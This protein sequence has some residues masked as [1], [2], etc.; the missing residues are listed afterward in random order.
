M[1]PK[2]LMHL[3]VVLEKG[4]ITGAARYLALTQPTLTRNMS[5]LEMQAGAALFTRSRFGVRSTP[6]GETLAREGRTI[7]RH[8]QEA[9]DAIA[10]HKLGPYDHIR[11]GIGP[12]LGMALMPQ[13]TTAFL[14]AF[15]QVALTLTTGRPGAL[16]DALAH[17]Q[18]DLVIAPSFSKQLPI[19]ISRAVLAQDSF[20][21]FCGSGHPL[22]ACVQ[23]DPQAL[24]DCEWVNAGLASP[25]QNEEL[26]FLQSN[27][28]QR[29]HIRFATVS[30]A[31][32]LLKVLEQ[33]RHAAVLSRLPVALLNQ[34]KRLH[35][36]V[37]PSVPALRE[38]HVWMR[39]DAQQQAA[40]T[41]FIDMAR[42]ILAPY[43]ANLVAS[44]RGATV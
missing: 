15:P 18:F 21:V 34:D 29:Q 43:V 16:L 38:I 10:R 6:L 40:V 23:V 9:A 19:G 36:V 13:L 17:G 22:A 12:W 3:A 27:G 35:E 7:A 24:S 11:V 30:D 41:G 14:A 4:S 42:S 1:D 32:V 8:M 20:G 44:L 37:L 25:F 28:V 2:H 39:G 5:T 31:V 33:G 26:E